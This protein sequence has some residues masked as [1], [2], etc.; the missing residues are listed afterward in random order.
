MINAVML[1]DLEYQ[2]SVRDFV[3]IP[4]AEAKAFVKDVRKLMADNLA[5][6]SLMKEEVKN[7]KLEAGTISRVC[8]SIE[9]RSWIY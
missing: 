7:I 8:E 4:S 5:L 1:N 2:S 9:H 6:K 3:E